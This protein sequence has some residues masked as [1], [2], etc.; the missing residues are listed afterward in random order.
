MKIG[1]IGIGKMGWPLASHLRKAGFALTVTD[2]DSGRKEAAD[3]AG[4][5]VSDL[6]G[7]VRQTDV[8][9]SSLPN[10]TALEVVADIVC[11]NG[12]RG[13]VIVDTSTVSVAVS[14]RVAVRCAAAGV[15]YL[16]VAL[17]GNNKMAEAR[18][19]TV[20]ASGPRPLYERLEP[21]LKCFGDACFYLG[22]AE[23]AR[24]M[25]MVIN[26]MVGQT[27]VMLAEAL[28]LGQKGGLAWTD[29]WHV[30]AS[31]AVA[32]P[33]VKAKAPLLVQRD[34]T[35]TFSVLQMIKDLTLIVE[36]ASH[37][38]LSLQGTDATLKLMHAAVNSGWEKEDYAAVIKVVESQSG[39]NVR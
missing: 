15:E 24:L 5:A 25:K 18:M 21:V 29:M 3:A 26:L 17:S 16:R 8:V 11:A 33:L 31:S 19:L 37:H 14:S 13:L 28:T 27:A 10:D 20:L 34:F 12:R 32:S 7:V 4:F 6:I 36:A 39:L 1:F 30:I 23:Q 2:A 38:G 9:I 22:D 35:P